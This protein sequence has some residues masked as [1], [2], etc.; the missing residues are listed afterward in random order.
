MKAVAFDFDGVIYNDSD[1][2]RS[3]LNEKP[4]RELV[5]KNIEEKQSL[6]IEGLKDFIEEN[7]LN[8]SIFP[9]SLDIILYLKS[10]GFSVG[11]IS[12][13]RGRLINSVLGKDFISSLNFFY[14]DVGFFDKESYL[15]KVNKSFGPEKTFYIGDEV[16]DVIA[17]KRAGVCSV[18]ITTGMGDIKDLILSKPDYIV[19]CLSVI[20]TII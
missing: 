8:L 17:A 9:R 2:I 16:R 1:L 6:L 5:G 3:Y 13:N 4:Y 12:S 19:K 18:A 15:Q 20:P 11:V 10:I 7:I 14:T